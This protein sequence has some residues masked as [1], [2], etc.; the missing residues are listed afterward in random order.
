[1]PTYPPTDRHPSA[2][3]VLALSAMVV[4]ALVRRPE[5][6]HT[7]RATGTRPAFL[8]RTQSALDDLSHTLGRTHA[9]LQGARRGLEA[10][11]EAV[12]S[13]QQGPQPTAPSRP[14]HAQKAGR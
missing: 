7:F 6:A 9:L 5:P 4:W 12:Q 13:G 2:L 3:A 8:A 1:M 10:I 11:G 14:G